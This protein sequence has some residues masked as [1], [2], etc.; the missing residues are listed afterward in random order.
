MLI[1]E[2]MGDPMSS[3][4]R[5]LGLVAT[6]LFGAGATVGCGG[7]AANSP[8]TTT[9]ATT[10][11]DDEAAAGLME[12]HRNHHHGGVTLFIAMSLDTLG[13]S[14]EQQ[15]ALDK[16]RSELHVAMEP[17]RVADQNLT[18]ALADGL[19]AG[20]FDAAKVDAGIAQVTAAV[21]KEHEAAAEA[22]NE[23]H[24]LLTPPQRGALVDKVESHWAVWQKANA[25]ETRP[26]EVTGSHLA[27]LATDLGLSK[28]QVER[29]RAALGEGMKSVPRLAPQEVEDY[30][31]AFGDAFRSEKFDAKGF[32]TASGVNS[33]MVNWG[34]A[35]MARFVETVSPLLTPDQRAAFADRLREHATHNP[36]AQAN[37]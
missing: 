25:D 5:T 29:I 8:A 12:H 2:A 13:V 20:S 3:L 37:P 33:H 18:A 11:D 1:G 16:V 22:L 28:D 15:A 24:S 31:R 7:S 27:M 10:A 34:A 17:A 35:H 14:P 19:T 32:S 6:V 36:S 26:G 23:L 21:A 9:A 4:A 30:V